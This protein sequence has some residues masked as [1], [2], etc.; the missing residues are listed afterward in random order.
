VLE[1]KG[2]RALATAAALAGKDPIRNSGR[3][4]FY[5]IIFC[6]KKILFFNPAASPERLA[7]AGKQS[8]FP[9]KGGVR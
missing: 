1:K 7:A 4:G 9:D 6:N 2:R 5:F 3:A 8:D